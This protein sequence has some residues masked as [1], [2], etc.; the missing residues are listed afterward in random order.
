MWKLAT[1]I[2]VLALALAAPAHAG[3]GASAAAWIEESPTRR[4]TL[5]ELLRKAEY[6]RLDNELTAY[7]RRHEAGELPEA[8][9]TNDYYAFWNSD[10]ALEQP[11]LAWQRAL[12][13][14]YAAPLATGMYYIRLGWLSRGERSVRET[15]P[16]RFAAMRQHFNEAQVHLRR[17]L[18][19]NDRLV[20]AYAQLGATHMAMG[21]KR[22]MAR[23]F[24]AGLEKAP[25][26]WTIHR[27]VLTSLEPRW[28]GAS[29]SIRRYLLAN[30]TRFESQPNLR[31]L[32]GYPDFE[33]GRRLWD[34]NDYAGAAAAFTAALS[35][36]ENGMYLHYRGRVLYWLDRFEEAMADQKLAARLMGS[37]FDAYA[38]MAHIRA[39]LQD[40][41]GALDDWNQ[42]V[43]L[44]PR[45]PELLMGRADLTLF[46]KDRTM[47]ERFSDALADLDAALEFGFDDPD[48]FSQRRLLFL[49]LGRFADAVGEAER[50][51]RL[52]PGDS[53]VWMGY[54]EALVF[55]RDCRAFEAFKT[56]QQLCKAQQT[57]NDPERRT[58]S[59]LMR[60]MR[61]GQPGAPPPLPPFA[62][63]R[64]SQ[65]QAE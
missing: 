19:L 32:L 9:V 14:S 8:A 58:F 2:M 3:S 5:I 43:K 26:S 49:E 31:S 13:Q 39:R 34:Q 63:P 64:E 50:A 45:N 52:A 33:R 25:Q 55:A 41:A 15:A 22:E 18:M 23:V 29:T 54:T 12:P 11:L 59:T 20:L 48:L 46:D 21:N 36:G 35:Y 37:S 53:K 51:L 27:T 47:S 16:E 40:Y 24:K 30:Q 61:C 1:T 38:R 60:F 57:C 17:A 10:A 28:G 56:F 44:D 62:M 42:A 65:Q 7:Q 6:E 4:A